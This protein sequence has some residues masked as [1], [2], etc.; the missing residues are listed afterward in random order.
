MDTEYAN[1]PD[2]LI[3]DLGEPDSP[4]FFK[5]IGEV[6]QELHNKI[7]SYEPTDIEA[8]LR[9]EIFVYDLKTGKRLN[10]DIQFNVEFHFSSH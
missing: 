9:N 6:R 8:Y 3:L 1:R 7:E 4:N 2:Y 5:T 10:I